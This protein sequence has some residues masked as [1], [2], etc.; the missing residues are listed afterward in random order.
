[1]PD[2]TNFRMTEKD[3]L[4]GDTIVAYFDSIPPKDTTSRPQINLLVATGHATSLQHLAPKDTS[5]CLPAISYVKGSV[6]TV[7]F[8]SAQVSTVK[9][10]DKDGAPG[11]YVEPDSTAEGAR[12]HTP[13]VAR[14][15]ADSSS[16]APAGRP[17]PTPPPSSPPRASVP[18]AVVPRRP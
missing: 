12:C 11:V 6:I 17:I 9:I 4:T 2:T 16:R 7:H 1:M 10:S 14:T 5:L 18:P 15:A 3:R 13:T 8:D